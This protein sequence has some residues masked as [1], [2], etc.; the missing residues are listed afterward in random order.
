MPAGFETIYV[1]TQGSDLAI[2]DAGSV[3]SFTV[4][5]EASIRFIRSCTILLRWTLG[6]WS[7]VLPPVLMSTHC[8]SKAVA[9]SAHRSMW[10]VPHSDILMPM[11]GTLSGGGEACL[12]GGSATITAATGRQRG[13]RC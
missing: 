2:V 7:S 8:S 12:V 11:A 9:T 5:F 6:S 4:G 1:L 10:Q 13:G 3:P